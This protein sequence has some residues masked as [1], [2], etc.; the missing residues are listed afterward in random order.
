MYAKT[1]SVLLKLPHLRARLQLFRDL[2]P[3]VRLHFLHSACETGI[4]TF[5]KTTPASGADLAEGL[6]I[7]RLELLDT[8]LALGV[9]LKEES[10]FSRI[11]PTKLVP[12]EPFYGILAICHDNVSPKLAEAPGAARHNGVPRVERLL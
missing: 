5:L 6:G 9:C 1:L 10:G 7:Q 8:P 4:L 11:E 2:K 3:Y 12:G